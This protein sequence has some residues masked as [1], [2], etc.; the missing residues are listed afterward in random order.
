[1]LVHAR[2][3]SRNDFSGLD[4]RCFR[5]PLALSLRDARRAA[6]SSTSVLLLARLGV[7]N[8]SGMFSFSFSLSCSLESS[9]SGFTVRELLESGHLSDNAGVAEEARELNMEPRKFTV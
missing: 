9:E 1:M 5:L 2:N 3:L 6:F 7:R 4:N 8:A